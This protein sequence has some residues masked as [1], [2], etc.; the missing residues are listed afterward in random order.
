MMAFTHT[1]LQHQCSAQSIQHTYTNTRLEHTCLSLNHLGLHLHVPQCAQKEGRRTLLIIWALAVTFSVKTAN[2]SSC[3]TLWIMMMHHHFKFDYKRFSSWGD[4]VQINSHCNSEP[5]LWPCPWQQQ[6]NPIIS[7]DNPV[8]DD[9]PSIEVSLQ[10]NQQFERGIK[11]YYFDYT[12]LHCGFD[13]KDSK[14]IFSKDTLDR[15][16]A[17]SYQVW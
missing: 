1:N 14:P 10:K 3:I 7:E 15:D 13:L 16:N 4:I 11:E 8:Y 9:V 5:F 6:N 2:Q 17:S 12:I